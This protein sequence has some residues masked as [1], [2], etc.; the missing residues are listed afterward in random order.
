MSPGFWRPLGSWPWDTPQL[1]APSLASQCWILSQL[2]HPPCK[3]CKPC[4]ATIFVLPSQ[5]LLLAL[6]IPTNQPTPVE[7]RRRPMPRHIFR[8]PRVP[9]SREVGVHC[10]PSHIIIAALVVPAQFVDLFLLLGF[11]CSQTELDPHITLECSQSLP[12]SHLQP[13]FLSFPAARRPFFAF[14]FLDFSHTFFN[15]LFL[16]TTHPPR[17]LAALGPSP[18]P[19]ILLYVTGIFLR[20]HYEYS[21]A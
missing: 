3:P 8:R 16:E 18:K 4:V 9:E 15:C 17:S 11:S 21:A 20:R 1:A 7:G 12:R 13:A 10:R 19:P 2:G 14:L 5:T 6:S